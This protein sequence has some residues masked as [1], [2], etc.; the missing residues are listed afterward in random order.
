MK[1]GIRLSTAFFVACGI[2]LG[3]AIP[4][5]DFRGA[6]Q[7]CA[8]ADD[9]S[10]EIKMGSEA[11]T[12]IAQK[13]KFVTDP[14]VVARITGIEA[15]LGEIADK[16]QVPAGF[17][18][19]K[20]YNFKYRIK[21]IDQ[22]DINA[23]SLPGG[24]IYIY[25]GLLD[26]L[27]TDDEIAAVLAHETAHAAHHH[28]PQLM[29]EESKMG[30]Q[31]ALGILV[32]LIAKVPSDTIGSLATGAQYAQMAVLNNHFS[33]KAEQDAD[34]T[35]MIYMMRA[36][37]NPLGMLSLLH[38]LQ[39]VED[40][41]PTID[42]GFLQDHP[43]TTERL[44]AANNEV[45]LLGF[46][47]DPGMLWK[48]S[49][50]MK[51]RVTNVTSNGMAA[52]R[53]SFGRRQVALVSPMARDEG[54]LAATALDHLLSI[55]GQ[56]YQVQSSGDSVYVAGKPIL[57]FTAADL[58]VQPVPTTTAEMAKVSAETIKDALWEVNVR[59]IQAQ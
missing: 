48:V 1:S 10:D 45:E 26:I 23:F 39:D 30:T 7:T 14:A 15:R 51:T 47:P 22:K 9:Q 4:A 28:V 37:Y 32:A 41:S 59:G 44:A 55:N 31:M 8:Y 42:L 11:E 29:H 2:V 53:I 56:I 17:G 46:K 24:A 13:S 58:A 57:T 18:N 50:A 38:R 35:G 40:R 54:A 34:H 20:V 49:G 27:Q 36:G 33:E 16:E 21:V 19:D 12:E 43:L 3:V 6:V 52:L 25:K 5:R